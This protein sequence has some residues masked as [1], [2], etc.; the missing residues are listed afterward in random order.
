VGEV[1]LSIFTLIASQPSPRGQKPSKTP[2]DPAQSQPECVGEKMLIA[3]PPLPPYPND[4]L[5]LIRQS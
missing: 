1:A 2:T 5:D 4:W 3:G